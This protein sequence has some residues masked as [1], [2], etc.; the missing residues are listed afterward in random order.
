LLTALGGGCQV[1]IGA[2]ARIEGS[3]LRMTGVVIDPNGSVLLRHEAEA[4]IDEAE[5]LGVAVARSLL[6]QGG[7]QI[8]R[9]VYGDTLKLAGQRIVVTRAREQ[10]GAL[11]A[12]LRDEG[13]D[14]VELPVIEF[15][16]LDFVVPDVTKYD[17]VIFTSVNGVDYFYRHATPTPGPRYCTIGPAT[18]DALRT[19]G[20]E[21]DV[22]PA[23]YVAEGVVAALAGEPLQG[24]RVLLP[25]ASVA[26][27]V[28][29]E[30]LSK[31]GA[32][33][34]VVPVYATGAP[35]D[36]AERAA[37]VFAIKPDWVT[38]TSAST[39]RSLASAAPLA[40]VK[41]ASIGPIT[42]SEAR[43]LGLEVAVEAEPYTIDGLVKAIA[44]RS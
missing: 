43:G 20:L 30:E 22:V 15:Q 1:P 25:R 32:K 34:D 10:A 18:A 7:R 21:P 14:V 33:V 27:D 5:R 39:V 28:I 16:A 37:Q 42:S 19:R 2:H 11:T 26:R 23:S 38:I 4:A 6:G 8:L 35:A 3:R 29:P 9:T 36:L 44:G 12:K 31:L 40:G 17:W 13:A 41:L 24:K